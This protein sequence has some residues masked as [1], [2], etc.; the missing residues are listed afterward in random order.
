VVVWP[1]RIAEDL[2][3]RVAEVILGSPTK[4]KRK[5]ER[6]LKQSRSKGK[7]KEDIQTV[8]VQPASF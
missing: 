7:R 3:H 5:T 2:L 8:P 6:D 4:P 1:V